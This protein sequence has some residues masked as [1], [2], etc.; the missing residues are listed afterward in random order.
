[1]SIANLFSPNDY[2]LFCK[3][4][5]TSGAAPIDTNTIDTINIGDTL[6]LGPVKAGAVSIA[7]AG[8]VT[9][10][11]GRLD[12]AT[13]RTDNLQ[14][15]TFGPIMQIGTNALGVNI[16]PFAGDMVLDESTV[17]VD[18]LFLAPANYQTVSI[19]KSTGAIL[20]NGTMVLPGDGTGSLSLFEIMTPFDGTGG[21]CIPATPGFIRFSGLRINSSIF[22]RF[23]FLGPV[24]VVTANSILTIVE[25]LPVN[26]RP[27]VD[28]R[29]ICGVLGV[30]A[31]PGATSAG[32][33]T[34]TALGVITFEYAQTSHDRR[35][36]LA[37]VGCVCGII[38]GSA[39]YGFIL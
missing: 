4:I 2:N 13:I 35:W 12:A 37:D 31:A 39:E 1:M 9:T 38:D 22:L 30:T 5:T 15:L 18:T 16:T 14:S 20:I 7:N 6:A 25:T 23:R 21:G 32:V 11:N 28:L 27:P 29:I 3:S 8:A 17:G 10:V 26:F 19:G 24:V 33:I 36:L 34:I